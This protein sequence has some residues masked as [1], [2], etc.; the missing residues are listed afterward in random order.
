[1]EAG[2]WELK[3]NSTCMLSIT[4]RISTTRKRLRN[5]RDGLTLMSRNCVLLTAEVI[6]HNHWS[7]PNLFLAIN[8][9][10]C[11]LKHVTLKHGRKLIKSAPYLMQLI[12]YFT[13]KFLFSFKSDF[14][15]LKPL[16][17]KNWSLQNDHVA[18]IWWKIPH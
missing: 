9:E 4:K 15:V 6:T 11:Q 13:L 1:M 18:L 8:N 14:E 3:F 10:H 16:S 7:A 17:G 5:R 2:W 12:K